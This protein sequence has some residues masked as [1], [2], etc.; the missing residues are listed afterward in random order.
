MYIPVAFECQKRG[1]ESI[2]VCGNQCRTRRHDD[3]QRQQCLHWLEVPRDR[4]LTLDL[5]ECVLLQ[6][7]P[8]GY[9]HQEYVTLAST[10]HNCNPNF[11]KTIDRLLGALFCADPSGRKRCLSPDR[12]CPACL[13][14]GPSFKV[15]DGDRQ[16]GDDFPYPGEA[17]AY[18][19]SF[20]KRDHQRS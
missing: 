3:N 11:A 20:P 8:F 9:A 4:D 18:A 16:L 15:Y 10:I 19:T 13:V 5:T 7:L 17:A 14:E 6:A 1:Q 12:R 2:C